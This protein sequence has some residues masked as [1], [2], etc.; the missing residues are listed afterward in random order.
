M[1]LIYILN[2]VPT[3][4][5]NYKGS[6]LYNNKYLV[7]RP[8]ISHFAPPYW[9]SDR[10][11]LGCGALYPDIL[12]VGMFLMSFG[13]VVGFDIKT[14]KVF[15]LNVLD[16]YLTVLIYNENKE[17]YIYEVTTEVGDAYR[18]QHTATQ[19]SDLYKYHIIKTRKGI[20]DAFLAP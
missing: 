19:L 18:F 16:G 2:A 14:S 13:S 11:L 8:M 7:P 12:C 15:K 3:K 20:I 5:L 1:I 4:I 17:M 10:I 9:S 6:R